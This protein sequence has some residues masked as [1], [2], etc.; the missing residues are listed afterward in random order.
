MF[1]NFKAGLKRLV[2]NIGYREI[3]PKDLERFKDDILLFLIEN[4]MA[5]DAAEALITGYLDYVT[6]KR[7][8]RFSSPEE[9]LYQYLKEYLTEMLT[10]LED[11]ELEKLVKEP[12][13]KPFKILVTGVNGTGKTTTLAKIAWRLRNMGLT[14]L[15]VCADTFRAGAIEQ[16]K[17]H[18]D[19][20]KLPFFS[21]GYGHDPAAVA[22]DALNH[23]RSKRYDVVLIDT[24]GRQY[25]NKNLMEELRKV[26]SV[27]EPDTTILV[28]DSLTGAD[29]ITQATE[30]DEG[31]GVDRYVFTKVDADVKG[32]AILSASVTRPKPISYLGIGQKYE[33]LI[34]FTAEYIIQQMFE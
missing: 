6:G 23:A 20:L 4:D 3:T 13:E 34:P 14:P 26:K 33:D 11:K 1:S 7:V 18:A 16:L 29:V 30:F 8:A 27:V 25:S 32:G 28:L 19:R 2:E 10:R 9:A 12:P 15:L 5:Y 31:V 17:T 22:Y 24:A 21:T